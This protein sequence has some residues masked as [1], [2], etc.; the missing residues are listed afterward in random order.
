MDF[1]INNIRIDRASAIG[2]NS[3]DLI[4]L[5]WFVQFSNGSKIERKYIKKENDM[6]YWV[7]YKTLMKSLPIIFNGKTDNGNR[8]KLRRMMNGNLSKVLT[9][10]QYSNKT[11]SGKGG[12]KVFIVLNRFVYESLLTS[13]NNYQPNTE[14]ETL[15]HSLGITLDNN[16]K[17]QLAKMNI[18]TLELA[19]SIAKDKN[20]ET[21][22]KYI[23]GIYNNLEIEA[24]KPQES[25]N[26]Q[27][28]VKDINHSL[29]DK[30]IITQKQYNTY[31][32]NSSIDVVTKK[33][34]FH[35]FNETFTQYSSDELDDIIEKSQ[36]AKFK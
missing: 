10:E 30:T 14:N 25:A 16:I 20:K 13:D 9:R 2:L 7:D 3:E 27:G 6:G 15:I 35:N 4:L 5:S 1:T 26:S 28:L 8:E 12:S 31:N 29:N 19:I 33:T 34:K 22:Y 32:N 36:K 18:N 11:E 23:K 17:G 21:N 24:K